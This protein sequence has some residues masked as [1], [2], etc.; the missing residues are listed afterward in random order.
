MEFS[1][2]LCPVLFNGPWW[3]NWVGMEFKVIFS[4]EKSTYAKHLAFWS[5]QVTWQLMASPRDADWSILFLAVF[6]LNAPRMSI[7][8]EM[9]FEKR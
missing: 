8:V 6:F 4:C 2:P 5:T 9:G 1:H 7:D 3:I